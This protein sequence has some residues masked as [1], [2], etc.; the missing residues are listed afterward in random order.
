[1]AEVE[2][3]PPLAPALAPNAAVLAAQLGQLALEQSLEQ[4]HSPSEQQT[5]SPPGAPSRQPIHERHTACSRLH[6][7]VDPESESAA[8]IKALLRSGE[9]RPGPAALPQLGAGATEYARRHGESIRDLVARKRQIFLAQMSLDTKHSEIAKL[10]QR[11][12]Q[13]EEAL[14]VSC[15]CCPNTWPCLRLCL[16]LLHFRAQPHPAPKHH[17]LPASCLPC[18]PDPTAADP[19]SPAASACRPRRRPWMQTPSGLRST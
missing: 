4:S 1:M 14:A 9:P 18:L 15:G 6:A 16:C 13:W 2:A 17:N 3:L 10:E 8:A 7:L 11:S 5:A 19:P 12:R